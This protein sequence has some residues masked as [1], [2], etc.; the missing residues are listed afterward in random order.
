[1]LL[2]VVAWEAFAGCEDAPPSSKH[3]WRTMGERELQDAVAIHQRPVLPLE[4]NRPMVKRNF[5]RGTSSYGGALALALLAGCSR[6]PTFDI[7]GSLFPAWLVCLVLG[8]LLAVVARWM[9]LR[10]KIDIAWP[11]LAY[12]SLAALFTFMLWLLL[13]G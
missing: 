9:L 2:V 4:E 13:F 7:M 6:A 1:I 12:P 11:V 3:P 8:I 10:Q 5:I